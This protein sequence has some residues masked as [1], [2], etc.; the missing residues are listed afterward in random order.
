MSEGV[1]LTNEI[2]GPAVGVDAPAVEVGSEIV[3]A[4]GRVG[5]QVPDCLLYTSNLVTP[6]FSPL[7]YS[8]ASSAANLWR[9][10]SVPFATAGW[11]STEI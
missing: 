2:A 3:E 5:E 10:S 4:G 11:N 1:E 8:V 7:R 6:S 9:L